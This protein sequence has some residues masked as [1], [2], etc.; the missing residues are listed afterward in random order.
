MMS[1]RKCPRCGERL[2]GNSLTCPKCYAEVSRETPVQRDEDRSGQPRNKVSA[3]VVLL[4]IIPAFFG[5]LG[6]GQIYR[7][8]RERKGYYFLI[9]GLVIFIP[10]AAL[11][12]IMLNSG[13]LSAIFLFLADVLLF[14]LYLSAA[15]A[16]LLDALFGSVFRVLKF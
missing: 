16:A 6:L 8:H 13:L 9:A 15:L 7:D 12:V 5:I 10:L 4:A 14:I 3:A 1:G 11:F 2:D